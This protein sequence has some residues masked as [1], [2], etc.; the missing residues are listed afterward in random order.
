MNSLSLLN[1]SFRIFFFLAI[2]LM[3]RMERRF[4]NHRTKSSRGLTRSIGRNSSSVFFLS[5]VVVAILF[6]HLLHLRF[7]FSVWFLLDTMDTMDAM[8]VVYQADTFPFVATIDSPTGM[9]I[10][11]TLYFQG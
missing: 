7:L 9:E 3:G 6:P 2:F 10:D 1:S 11:T 5:I 4:C 8:Q